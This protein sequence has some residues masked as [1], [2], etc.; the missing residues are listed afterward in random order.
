[1]LWS[2]GTDPVLNSI[3]LQCHT[4]NK[5]IISRNLSQEYESYSVL[6]KISVLNLYTVFQI[7]L[8]EAIGYSWR[9]LIG[10]MCSCSTES[11]S[12]HFYLKFP[13]LIGGIFVRFHLQKVLCWYFEVWKHWLF[14]ISKVLPATK[15]LILS[16]MKKYV[17][18]QCFGSF[19]ILH[20]VIVSGGSLVCIL[21]HQDTWTWYVSVL[22]A[23]CARSF[24]N[25]AVYINMAIW[26]ANTSFL[27]V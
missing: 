17:R 20:L 22:H 24:W 4:N 26:V 25:H 7:I 14:M 3:S 1:M 18:N 23:Q 10:K 15:H 19:M 2:K 11:E 27:Q 5:G 16:A 12:L 6:S 8:C 21:N 9:C 13:F